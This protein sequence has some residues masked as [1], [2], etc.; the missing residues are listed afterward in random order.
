M[1]TDRPYRGALSQQQAINELRAGAGTQF[2]PRVIEALCVAVA[3]TDAATSPAAD[4]V[5]ALLVHSSVAERF[6]A[7]A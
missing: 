1:T 6:G 4:E 7:S 2:D 3:T 5:R